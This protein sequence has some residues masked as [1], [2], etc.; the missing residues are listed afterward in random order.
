MPSS[1]FYATEPLLTVI[2]HPQ[3]HGTAVGVVAQ[4]ARLGPGLKKWAII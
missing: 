3:W 4:V 2:V 1:C